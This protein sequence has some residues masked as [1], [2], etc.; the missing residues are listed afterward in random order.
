MISLKETN[1]IAKLARIEFSDKE[2]KQLQAEL[3]LI[4]GY[5]DKLKEVDIKDIQPMGHSVL[6]KNVLRKDESI[7]EKKPASKSL[8]DWAPEKDEGFVKVKSVFQK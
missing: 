7:E 6:V 3:S 1:H 2:L 4:L 5:I 8:V